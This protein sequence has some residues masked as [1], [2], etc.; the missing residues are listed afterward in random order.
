MLEFWPLF[1]GHD[2]PGEGRPLLD[3]IQVGGDVRDLLRDE[4]RSVL[5]GAAEHRREAD[6]AVHGREPSTERWMRSSV[7]KKN[8]VCFYA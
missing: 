8:A 5:H 6:H 7:G 2:V 4:Q 1:E 3:A